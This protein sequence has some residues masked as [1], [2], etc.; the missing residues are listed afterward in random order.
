MGFL[1]KLFGGGQPAG[2]QGIYFYVRCD[3]CGEPIRVRA[4][5][6]SDLDPVFEGAGD[7]ASGFQLNKEI[8]GS[9]CNNLIYGHWTFDKSRRVIGSE[10]EGGKAITAGE[11]SA[12]AESLQAH[13]S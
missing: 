12:L 3:R 9:R 6:S 1:K 4:N 5:P 10:I 7:D 2:D 13:G 11:Y 8:L